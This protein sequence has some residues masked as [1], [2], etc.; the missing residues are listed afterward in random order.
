[1]VFHEDALDKCEITI[2]VIQYCTHCTRFCMKASVKSAVNQSSL[3]NID[4]DISDQLLF[5]RT[6]LTI[7]LG[8]GL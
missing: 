6:L 5:M 2:T 8:L 7:V 1:M 4:E 3:I